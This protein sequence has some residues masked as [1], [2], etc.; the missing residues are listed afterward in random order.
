MSKLY[1]CDGVSVCKFFHLRVRPLAPPLSSDFR[2]S[3]R[4]R[5][6]WSKDVLIVRCSLP[7]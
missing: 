4:I 2:Y 7:H 3:N 6:V 5:P 1:F